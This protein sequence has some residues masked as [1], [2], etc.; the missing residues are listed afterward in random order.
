MNHVNAETLTIEQMMTSR[1]TCQNA[2]TTKSSLFF[3]A[4]RS[5]Y[6]KHILLRI[7]RQ[8]DKTQAVNL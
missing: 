3:L 2:P 5:R 8:M 7:S 1:N 4:K 6:F